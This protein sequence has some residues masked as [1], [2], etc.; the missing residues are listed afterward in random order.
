MAARFLHAYVS[1]GS[2]TLAF[3]L[4]RV[5]PKMTV[6]LFDVPI[7]IELVQKHFIPEDNGKLNVRLVPG[8]DNIQSWLELGPCLIRPKPDL[9]SKIRIL[10]PWGCKQTESWIRIRFLENKCKIWI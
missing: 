3:E 10:K 8:K 9:D 4:S 5:Y 1:G 2:G 6:N 7:V